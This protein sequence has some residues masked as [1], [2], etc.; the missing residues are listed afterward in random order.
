[1]RKP[2]LTFF[3][4]Y[5][6][7]QSSIGG[8]QTLISSFIKYAPD[9]FEIR[10]V[11]VGD[12]HSGQIGVWQETELHGRKLLFFPLFGLE[13]DDV[14]RLVPTTIRYMTALMEHCFASDFMHF[15]RIEPTLTTL[16]WHGDKT[17]FIHN[18]IRTQLLSPDGRQAILWSLFPKIYFALEGLLVS[19]FSRI[20]SC[21]SDSTELYKKLYPSL[22]ERVNYYRNS[23]DTDIF[24]PLSVTEQQQQRQQLAQ[25]LGLSAATR[26]ILFAGRL[27]PQKDPLLLVRSLSAVNQPNVHLLIAGDGE[28]AEAVRMEVDRLGLTK[29]VTMLGALQ[30]AELADLHRLAS[31]CLLTSVYEGL[32]LVVLEALAC[33]T[34][35]VT[36]RCGDIPAVLTPGSG[37][38]CETRSPMAIATAIESVLQQPNLYSAEACVLAA[39]PY[40]AREV[41]HQIYNDMLQRWQAR[42]RSSMSL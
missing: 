41:M 14:R 25:K 7:W 3:Y 15:H 32:P 19:Q 34:P 31:I 39:Q 24:Y 13:N 22:A 33:G 5:N 35:I 38:V 4:Q 1:M 21:N 42:N 11:G 18:D 2:V 26:F 8:I 36:T 16:R 27:H 29:Q 23:V 12:K 37:I 20:L 40:S 30:Q 6:P 10:L 9:E 28:L 17:L